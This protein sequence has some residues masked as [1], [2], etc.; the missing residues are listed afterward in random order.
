MVEDTAGDLSKCST[1]TTK[2]FPADHALIVLSRHQS[3]PLAYLSCYKDN[4]VFGLRVSPSSGRSLMGNAVGSDDRIK[5]PDLSKK[6]NTAGT[7]YA[8]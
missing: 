8:S 3:S 4:H 2:L 7:V 6:R 5:P 1:I